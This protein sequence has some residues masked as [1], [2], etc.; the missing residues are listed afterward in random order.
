MSLLTNLISY[1]AFESLLVDSVGPNLLTNNNGVTQ[2]T[3]LVG[4]AASFAA[5]STQRLSVTSNSSQNPS[6]S[7]T[8]DGWINPTTVSG[9]FGVVH[10]SQTDLHGQGYLV[11]IA[12]GTLQLFTFNAGTTQGNVSVSLS[13][14]VWTYF[15]A[16]YD[17]VAVTV[18]IQLNNGAITTATALGPPLTSTFP[19]IFGT[20]DTGNSAEYYNGLMDEFGFWSRVLTTAESTARYNAGAGN[21]YPFGLNPNPLPIPQDAT[22]DP[23][24]FDD[25][26]LSDS[27][28]LINALVARHAFPQPPPGP[29]V[30]PTPPK[31]APLTFQR[32]FLPRVPNLFDD[33]GKV[34]K[35]GDD[36]LR[37]FTE[38]TQTVLN[39][40]FA[41]GYIVQTGENVYAIHGGGYV[42][43]RAPGPNDDSTVGVEPLML[44]LNSANDFVYLNVSN[45]IGGAQWVLLGGGSSSGGAST[46]TGAFL[47]AQNE[48]GDALLIP[49]PTGSAGATGLQGFP[50]MAGDDG[51][52][53]FPI[54]VSTG[55]IG[56]MGPQGNQGLTGEDGEDA[57]VVPGPQGLTG[58]TG[59]QG[60]A[61]AAGSG[62]SPIYLPDDDGDTH[63]MMP[64]GTGMPVVLSSA[65]PTNY[66]SNGGMWFAQRSNPTTHFT[67]ASDA[68]SADRW[69][70]PSQSVTVTYTR[71]DTLG[72]QLTGLQARYYGQW[73]QNTNA[74]KFA[75]V[76]PVEGTTTYDLDSRVVTFQCKLAVF[77]TTPP[78][79]IR[80][81]ILQLS[82]SGTMD[83]IPSTLVPTW[84]ANTVDPTF[85]TN[86]TLL[87]PSSVPVGANGTISGNAVSCALT[88]TFQQ[89]AGTFTIGANT[90]NIMPV[91]FTDSQMVVNGSLVMSEAG[92]YIG[93]NL[94]PWNPLT[95]QQELAKCQ[96]YY[97][98]SYDID[99]PP[100]TASSG[101][102]LVAITTG[103]SI[104]TQ[105][106]YGTPVFAV[107][108]RVDPSVTVYSFAGT[109]GVVSNS[110]ATDLAALS[111]STTSV[112]QRSFSC[113]NG[114]GSS[115]MTTTAGNI[116]FHFAA[117]AEL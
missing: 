48:D 23:T 69:K 103:A 107:P 108:M 46:G 35:H 21:T 100:A 1:W 49:G 18:N 53:A 55:A 62:G 41:A 32:P 95:P 92:L 2:A 33:S 11:V 60:P 83:T 5:A 111:G 74:G 67:V 10:N 9:S 34:S 27:N 44:W 22:F 8:W 58:A 25:D 102:G 57:L 70:V 93:S 38:L 36:R 26:D 24:A 17:A 50:G 105:Q 106:V 64:P 68:Y 72:S 54:R 113:F 78:T 84:G 56:P 37:R 110:A 14:N 90:V 47:T 80:L 19:L 59:P 20:M 101:P 15:R 42:Q 12:S 89:F 117:S 29:P 115:T 39:S 30:P 88:A 28:K 73:L 85:A 45:V 4:K 77:N 16:W 31:P 66:L 91:V 97:Q 13:A 96:R 52:D 86:V 76:Q 65:T 81:G 6:G 114:T 61:G 51:E 104:L 109:T 63:P 71:T 87:A 40:L 94:V 116:L 79:T 75:V 7:F 98:K 112:G 43:A 99:I 3:G 82:S